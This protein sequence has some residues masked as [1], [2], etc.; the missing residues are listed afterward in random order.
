MISS[1]RLQ[2]AEKEGRQAALSTQLNPERVYVG[3]QKWS[4]QHRRF[5]KGWSRI[6]NRFK[7][8]RS[9]KLIKD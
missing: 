5:S 9:T 4:A 6:F 2:Q 8:L 1:D 3:Y 7:F